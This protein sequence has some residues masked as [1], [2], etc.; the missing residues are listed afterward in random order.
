M[1][2]LIAGPRPLPDSLAERLE[3][4][5]PAIPVRAEF[6]LPGYW[7]DEQATEVVLVPADPATWVAQEVASA[8]ALHC[9]WCGE[10]LAATAISCVFCGHT[11]R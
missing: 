8:A 7:G 3:I 6:D 5:G 11:P 9:G 2:L 1:H 4:P 10:M